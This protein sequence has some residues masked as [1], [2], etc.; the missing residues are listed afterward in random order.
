MGG[1]FILHS[2]LSILALLLALYQY[3]YTKYRIPTKAL[4]PLDISKSLKDIG[5]SFQ[6]SRQLSRKA[7]SER[8]DRKEAQASWATSMRRAQSERSSQPWSSNFQETRMEPLEEDAEEPLDETM[9]DNTGQ[10]DASEGCSRGW[11]PDRSDPLELPNDYSSNTEGNRI[12]F[13]S[14]P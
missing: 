12:S 13:E 2:V 9:V 4:R 7:Q 10:Y 5:K 1:I 14:S 8:L 3:F 11:E 6:S